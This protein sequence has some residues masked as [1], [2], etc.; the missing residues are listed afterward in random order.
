MAEIVESAV[1]DL[2]PY[3]RN[4]RKNDAVVDQM[5]ASIRRLENMNPLPPEQGDV[6]LIPLNMVQAG[7]AG[8]TSGAVIESSGPSASSGQGST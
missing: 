6:Y 3:A 1:R 5:A 8:K 2:I 4:P 7:S